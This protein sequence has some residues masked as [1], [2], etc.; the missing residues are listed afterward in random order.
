MKLT[1]KC[2]FL[3]FI[4]CNL[5]PELALT[6]TKIGNSYF[7]GFNPYF[8]PIFFFRVNDK[9]FNVYSKY[10]CYYYDPSGH[11]LIAQ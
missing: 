3:H 8:L 7:Q 1:I 4:L 6:R 10:I 11:M 2:D 9:F 5:V